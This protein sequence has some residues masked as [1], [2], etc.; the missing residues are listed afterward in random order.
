MA[1]L[2]IPRRGAGLALAC[3]TSAAAQTPDV[4][5]VPTSVDVALTMLRIAGVGDSDVV[6]DL[7]SGDGR[8]VISA[9]KRFGARGV[10]IDIDPDRVAD[11]IRNADTAGVTDRVAFRQA[12][13]FDTDLRPATVVTLYLTSSLNERLRPKLLRELRPG[14]RVVSN[15]FDM[16]AWTPDSVAYV[17]GKAMARTPVH[18]WVIPADARGRWTVTWD[19]LPPIRLAIEQRFQQ[20]TGIATIGG[21]RS[22]LASARLRGDSITFSI[23][24]NGE[25]GTMR[26]AGRVSGDSARGTVTAGAG[27]A[28]RAWRAIRTQAD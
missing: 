8:L 18:F 10:G 12:D 21:R 13:L 19:G 9:A 22:E 2:A 3:A 27:A 11:G 16:G 28:P 4:V 26:F 5:F 17:Q 1:A 14:S 6:Y 15:N 24:G 23:P 7:G 20:A 25:G